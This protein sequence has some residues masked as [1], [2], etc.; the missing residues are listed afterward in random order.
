M[1]KPIAIIGA[2]DLQLPLIEKAKEMGLETHVF[3]WAAGDA[4]ERAADVF[5][6][7]S[8]TETDAITDVCR[9]IRPCAVVSIASD[10]A[11][12]TVNRAANALGLPANPPETALIATNKYEMRRTF[13]E[14]GIPVPAFAR[15]SAGE[16]LSAIRHIITG[17]VFGNEGT[18]SDGNLSSVYCKQSGI[19][20]RRSRW[21]ILSLV[22]SKFM[23]SNVGTLFRN[24]T[25]RTFPVHNS[26]LV[27][28]AQA[29]FKGSTANL[30][31]GMELHRRPVVILFSERTT[32]DRYGRL[33]PITVEKIIVCSCE[34]TS[35]DDKR[36][37][38][39]VFN[40]HII[41]RLKGT[42]CDGHGAL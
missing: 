10:L 20:E 3:A 28:K 21:R 16:D 6:P 1:K 17:S 15:V 19:A 38:I 41:Y 33:F 35:L 39:I 36:A 30:C 12:I 40:K 32:Q 24:D 5:Y 9:S 25:V 2:S 13:R 27:I 29:A 37:G 23:K 26:C 7:I 11:A 22:N 34:G 42:A 31:Q 18:S 14:A 8:I 4:G